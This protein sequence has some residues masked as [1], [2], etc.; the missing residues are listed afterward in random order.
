MA[1]VRLVSLVRHW[2]VDTALALRA[3]RGSEHRAA[4]SLGVTAAVIRQRIVRLVG[5]VE[6]AFPEFRFKRGPHAEVQFG[7]DT[8]DFG[9]SDNGN[10]ND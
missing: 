5:R 10:G 3:S 7:Y 8:G 1:L 4:S 2:D 9:E 6:G